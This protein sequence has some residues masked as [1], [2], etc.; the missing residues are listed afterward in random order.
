VVAAGSSILGA[1]LNVFLGFVSLLV[2]LFCDFVVVT[3][4]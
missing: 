3:T 2:A 1:G 4:P